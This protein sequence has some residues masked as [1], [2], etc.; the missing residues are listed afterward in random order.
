MVQ[1]CSVIGR[2]RGGEVNAEMIGVRNQILQFLVRIDQSLLLLQRLTCVKARGEECAG[3][4][5]AL[6]SVFARP[7]SSRRGAHST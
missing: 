3:R 2:M 5:A 1:C 7:L 6:R 4:Q